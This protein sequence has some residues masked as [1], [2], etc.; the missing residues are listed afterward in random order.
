MKE[1]NLT[2]ACAFL[3]L[4]AAPALAG[5]DALE[6]EVDTRDADRFAEIFK[7]SGGAPD[8]AVLQA[9]YIDPGTDG[10]RIFI[11][12]RIKSGENL[13]SAIAEAP[14][15]YRRAIDVCLPIAKASSDELRAVYLALEGLLGDPDLPA[16]YALFGAGNSGGTAGPGT[17]VIGL[18]VICRLGKDETEIRTLLRSFF[19]H[20]TVH[21]LQQPQEMLIESAN[22]LSAAVIQE[23]TADYIA[24][25]VTGRP[26]SPE[27]AAWA[28]PRE[29][30]I[31]KE[32]E[33]DRR[34]TEKL[35]SEEQYA[36]GAPIYRW[37]ANIGSPPEGWPGE[38]GYWLGMR[39]AEAYVDA[40]PD[41]RAAV[42]ELISMRDPDA[43]IEKSGYGDQF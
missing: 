32:F 26:L 40:A 5:V 12:G 4:F 36:K 24:S 25:L 41:K 1:L 23:G 3:F 18:E 17:Q 19:A 2:C 28:L 21:T 27:R 39:I 15:A 20:E 9:G 6:A 37:V 7:A 11:Q 29:K 8:A 13:A 38:L 34:K 30:E 31:W 14:E 42:E 16:I 33:K 35:S 10:L 43:I 22:A